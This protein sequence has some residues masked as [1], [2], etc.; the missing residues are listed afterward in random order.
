MKKPRLN[1]LRTFDAAG[2]YMNFSAAAEDLKISQSAVSQ[3]IRQLEDYLGADLFNRHNRRLSLTSTG[4]AYFEVVRE[5]LD[6]LDTVTAQ[7]FPVRERQIVSLLCSSSIAALWLVPRLK[8]LQ[9]KYPGIELRINTLDQAQG[10]ASNSDLEI[11][12]AADGQGG[13]DVEPLLSATV[14]PIC[15]PGLLR[16]RERPRTPGDLLEYELIHV[17]GYED[18]WHRWF[19][20]N[21]V[22]ESRVPD[23]LALDGSLIAIEAAQRGEGVMLGRRPFIDRY[24]ESGD[25]VEVF[26]EP[27]H[28]K[29]EY[30]LRRS[31]RSANRREVERVADWL[32]RLALREST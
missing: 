25:L 5:T 17:L 15:S 6:R 31:P 13:P 19:R 27:W 8:S 23:G 30:C 1:L 29:A 28:L 9:R 11:C 3:Q 26:A 32:H 22:R 4:Q 21:G 18:G 7:L 20:R 24:L 2:R 12:I 16:Q 10:S 14:T